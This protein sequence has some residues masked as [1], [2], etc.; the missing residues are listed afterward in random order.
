MTPT[1]C[2]SIEEC[3]ICYEALSETT[4]RCTT[5]CGHTLCFTCMIR[6]WNA[7]PAHTDYACPCCRFV[8]LEVPNVQTI[9]DDNDDDT[10]DDDDDDTDEEDE[11][12]WTRAANDSASIERIAVECITTGITLA[13]VLAVL[14][15]RGH[16][17]HTRSRFHHPETTYTRPMC[18]ELGTMIYDI[19]DDLDEEQIQENEERIRQ[20]EECM[21]M[22][23]E[24]NDSKYI[25]CHEK[26]R[27]SH[28]CAQMYR[29]DCDGEY[30]RYHETQE[31]CKKNPYPYLLD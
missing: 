23:I 20:N 15:S 10:D 24:D 13:D 25:H 14:I 30:I 19:I 7:H 9:E 3:P 5:P 29:E 8:L 26:I 22:G 2:I 28:E 17:W 12:V 31:L 16:R 6:Y 27:E 18:E 21:Q 4:N 11:N 1:T